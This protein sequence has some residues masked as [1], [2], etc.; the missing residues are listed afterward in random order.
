M[1][2]DFLLFSKNKISWYNKRNPDTPITLSYQELSQKDLLKFA[3]LYN[4]LSGGTVYGDI[5]PAAPRYFRDKM[6]TD[7]ADAKRNGLFAQVLR[8]LEREV[9]Q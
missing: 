6:Q 7:Y 2:Q 3:A 5:Q 4:G 8:V 9:M 1:I